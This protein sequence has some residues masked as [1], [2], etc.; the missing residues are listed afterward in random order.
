[1]ESNFEKQQ[2]RADSPLRAISDTCLYKTVNRFAVIFFACLYDGLGPV[3]VVEAVGP[4]L[5]LEAHA[6]V[7]AVNSAILAAA[8]RQESGSIHLQTRQRGLGFHTDAGVTPDDSLVGTL[9]IYTLKSENT[10]F[11]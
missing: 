8:L 6:V 1:M 3:G 4:E 7:L 9:A 10:Y 2:E 11:V 5:G